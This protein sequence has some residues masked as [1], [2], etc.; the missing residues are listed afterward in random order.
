MAKT[1][2]SRPYTQIAK[3]Y[4]FNSQNWLEKADGYGIFSEF[5]KKVA[6]VCSSDKIPTG[7]VDKYHNKL[8]LCTLF[9]LFLNFSVRNFV[10]G[11]NNSG[12]QLEFILTGILITNVARVLPVYEVNF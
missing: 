6:V 7:E 10:S 5:F 2:M 11:A 12:I 4:I 9:H 8:Y 3:K 1:I